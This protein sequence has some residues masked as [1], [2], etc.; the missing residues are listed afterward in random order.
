MAFRE[1]AVVEIERG[2]VNGRGE[3]YGY[4]KRR[5]D[6]RGA[7]EGEVHWTWI[8]ELISR[9]AKKRNRGNDQQFKGIASKRKTRKGG[10]RRNGVIKRNMPNG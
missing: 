10:G 4:S 6:L 3:L 7:M 8:T 5:N 9:S 2:R 1:E